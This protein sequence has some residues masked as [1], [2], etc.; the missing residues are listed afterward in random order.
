MVLEFGS[1]YRYDDREIDDA[2]T[3]KRNVY[4]HLMMFLT[5]RLA[6]TGA[7]EQFHPLIVKVLCLIPE[8]V[9][10]EELNNAGLQQVKPE[11]HHRVIEAEFRECITA[12]YDLQNTYPGTDHN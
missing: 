1:S 11:K 9:W 12:G 7:T 3:Q 5:K 4:H 8:P 10:T 2:D 6:E